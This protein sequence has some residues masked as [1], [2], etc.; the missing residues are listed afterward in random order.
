[1]FDQVVGSGGN[2][3]LIIIACLIGFAAGLGYV[4]Y[5]RQQGKQGED[6]PK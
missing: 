1:M 3:F 2:A 6:Q 4:D 5:I